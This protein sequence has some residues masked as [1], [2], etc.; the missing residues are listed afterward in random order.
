MMQGADKI[1]LQEIDELEQDVRRFSAGQLSLEDFRPR[2]TVS[3]NVVLRWA[4][5][6][7]PPALHAA[8]ARHDLAQATAGTLLDPLARPGA[9]TCASAITSGEAMAQGWRSGANECAV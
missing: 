2:T 4:G 8:L 1:A 5:E 9:G 7:H 6:E 3:Q